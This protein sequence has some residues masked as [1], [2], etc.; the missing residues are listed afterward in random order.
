MVLTGLRPEGNLRF[1]LPEVRADVSVKLGGDE[2]ACPAP[3][4]TVLIDAERRQVSLVWRAGLRVQ[5]RVPQLRWIRV[6]AVAA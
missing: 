3:C 4:D 5:G 6:A 2:V 1:A